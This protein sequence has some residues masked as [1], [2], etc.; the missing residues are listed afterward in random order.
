MEAFFHAASSRCDV[1]W[2]LLCLGTLPMPTP[3]HGPRAPPPRCFGL[4]SR[5][6][7]V[8]RTDECEWLRGCADRVVVL[9][10]VTARL[11]RGRAQ[12]PVHDAGSATVRDVCGRGAPGCGVWDL[13]PTG[14][15]AACY[16]ALLV[17]RVSV[18][19][20]GPLSPCSPAAASHLGRTP[21][22]LA[23]K[24]PPVSSTE[25]R[26]EPTAASRHRCPHCRRPPPCLCRPAIVG[27]WR[28]LY[29]PAR[30][31]FLIRSPVTVGRC[32]CPACTWAMGRAPWGTGWR[33]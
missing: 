9:V 29:R 22:G 30:N 14:G 18:P 17:E 1:H 5:P 31:V 7:I 32:L 16:A 12:A 27:H 13:C 28:V 23:S 26:Q 25:H 15:G 24:R 6:R 21:H 20:R 3:A 19:K 4:S 8:L 33:P 11:R 2:A 10:D